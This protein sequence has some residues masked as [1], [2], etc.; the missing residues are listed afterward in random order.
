MSQAENLLSTIA[1]EDWPTVDSTHESEPMIVID[2]DRVIHVPEKLRRIAVQYDHNIETVFFKCPRYWDSHDLSEMAIYIT[3]LTPDGKVVPYAARGIAPNLFDDTMSFSWTITRDITQ[4]KGQLTFLVCIKKTDEFGLENNHW[5]SELNKEM[6]ISEGLECDVESILDSQPAL[7]TDILTRLSS[8]ERQGG[9]GL[10]YYDLDLTS[11]VTVDSD[12]A[13]ANQFTVDEYIDAAA[14]IAAIDNGQTVRIKFLNHVQ[15]GI[16]DLIATE[17]V[18]MTSVMRHES[19]IAISGVYRSL[20]ANYSTAFLHMM[21]NGDAYTTELYY[22]PNPIKEYVDTALEG[23]L[24]DI[25]VEFPTVSSIKLTKTASGVNI[26]VAYSDYTVSD[27]TVTLDDDGYPN[28]INV[29]GDECSISW[30]GF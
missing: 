6:Y 25:T 22:T 23:S 27:T 2:E 1:E 30:E 3:V 24:D 19:D 17:F 20:D 8:L 14:L 18:T 4:V 11:H 10:S 21:P 5:N 12:L 15:Y 16:A 29:D 7:V 13:S 28:S 9:G 26:H